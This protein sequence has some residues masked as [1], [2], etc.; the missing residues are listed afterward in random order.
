MVKL[1][2]LGAALVE[3]T[4]KICLVNWIHN[5]V[6]VLFVNHN[7]NRI[8]LKRGIGI[9]ELVIKVTRFEGNCVN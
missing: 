3:P 8:V 1:L 7:N 4:T 2:D 9:G 5:K 6:P